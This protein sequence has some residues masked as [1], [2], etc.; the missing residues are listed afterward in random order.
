M[1]PLYK[2]A[3]VLVAVVLACFL[4]VAHGKPTASDVCVFQAGQWTSYDSVMQCIYSVPVN[5]AVKN[6]TIDALKKALM[7]YTFL[8][9][10]RD[11]P[12]PQLPCHVDML[13]ALDYI[14]K[15]PHK[16]DY[17]F[18]DDLRAL[19]LLLGDAH[20][21]YYAPTCYTTFTAQQPFAPISVT[22]NGTNEQIIVV[23]EYFPTS[24][25]NYYQQTMNID[26]RSF[27]GA[28]IVSIDGY[29]ALPYLIE[30]ANSSVG[31]SKDLGS[32]F[33]Y[34]LTRPN[35]RPGTTQG[36]YSLSHSHLHPLASPNSCT[37]HP[38]D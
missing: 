8:D 29:N 38:Y 14:L 2:P 16:F 19:F 18:H 26:I 4:A 11:S 1:A 33:N 20:T 21:Q 37:A 25:I 9:I 35:P 15:W 34:A 32:R 36:V 12:D 3:L 22:A 5:N 31:M 7:L 10:S 28:Q 30:Y 6:Q 13:S 23:S 27:S 24:L 17:S